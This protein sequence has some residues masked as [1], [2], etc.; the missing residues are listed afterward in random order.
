MKEMGFISTLNFVGREVALWVRT[1]MQYV[2][3]NSSMVHVCKIS[4][5]NELSLYLFI[6]IFIEISQVIMMSK[7]IGDMNSTIIF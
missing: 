4:Y 3:Q 2:L 1:C 5:D 6:S 7:N